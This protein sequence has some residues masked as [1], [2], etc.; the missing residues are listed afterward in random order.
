MRNRKFERKKERNEGSWERKEKIEEEWELIKTCD[1][2]KS[3]V[4]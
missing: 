3:H 4:N 2:I 1:V